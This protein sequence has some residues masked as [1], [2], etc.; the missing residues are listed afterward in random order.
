MKRVLAPLLAFATAGC[1]DYI[2][3]SDLSAER[4][5]N[6]DVVIRFKADRDVTRSAQFYGATLLVPDQIKYGYEGWQSVRDHGHAGAGADRLIKVENPDQPGYY[7]AS[8]P[9]KG[10]YVWERTT[11]LMEA[12][13]VFPY[14][15]T[16]RGVY[17][18]QFWAG[19]GNCMGPGGF[20]TDRVTLYYLA[21]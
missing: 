21:P 12:R 19:G 15:L 9:L 16:R 20:F 3:I 4:G 5:A 8:F 18:L 11:W 1:Q 10:E 14:D 7:Q 2:H 17:E 13:T 6:D